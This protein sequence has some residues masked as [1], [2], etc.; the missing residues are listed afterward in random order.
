MPFFTCG[1]SSS[2]WIQ[3]TDSTGQPSYAAPFAGVITSWSH[4]A[5]SR[6]ELFKLK[7]VRAAGGDYF[8][9]IG[10]STA[11][12]GDP[13]ALNT[14]P[15]RIPVRAGDRIGVFRSTSWECLGTAPGGIIHRLLDI[16]AP[17]GVPTFFTEGEPGHT[18]NVSATLEPDADGDGFG[19]ETQDQCPTDPAS[20]A[21]PPDTVAPDTKI[22]AGPVKIAT[23]KAS[24]TFKSTEPGSSFECK[25]SGKKAKKML[26]AFKPCESPQ[27]YK[28]L[29]P[30]T[31]KFT[32]R[33]KDAAGNADESPAKRRFKV[34]E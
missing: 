18:I 27:K 16:D 33:A 1:P 25:L 30:G 24:F 12:A 13:N 21:C 14:F 23:S 29:R 15:T 19:D 28:G 10:E 34:V 3:T 4:Q 6:A 22:V 7:V 11:Q 8:T 17:L 20:Q 2:T 32:V 5:G 9:V 31:Y 26:K